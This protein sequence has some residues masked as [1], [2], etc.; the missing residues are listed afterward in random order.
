MPVTKEI[1]R[2][3]QSNVK[4]NMTIPKEDVLSQYQ[5]LLKDYSKN[6]QLP[7]FRKGKVP[8]N[9][10]ERKFGEALREEALGKIIEKTIT[11]IFDDENMPKDEKPLPYS[12]PELQEEPKL[13]FEQ[14][15]SFSI[16]YDVMPK[17]S[18][19]QWKG[20]EVEVPDVS[21]SEEDLNRELE[22]LRER[23]AF[24]LD[25]D[26]GAEAQ[27][28][29]LVT[30]DHCELDDTGEVLPDSERKDF[31]FTLGSSQNAYMFDDDIIGM[32]K[33]DAKEFTKTYPQTPGD[34]VF[35]GKTL[36]L[37]VTLT[38]LKEKKLPD[39]DDDLAQDIDEKFNTLDDLKN[40]I[41]ERLGKALEQRLK[42]LKINGLLE[43]IMENSPVSL[44]ESMVRVELD[45]RIRNL[46]R[47]FGT[48]TDRIMQMLAEDGQGLEDIQGK[49][50]PSAEKALHSRIILETI[51]EEQHIE[52][53]DNEIG[54]EMENMAG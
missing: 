12:R 30:I 2:L 46:A 4:L 43:K 15:L 53:N 8:H 52:V 14:D 5:D 45:G 3:E 35:A 11:E 32:K 24:V 20:L 51:M 28:G 39:L 19:G 25:R 44:P 27:N 6:V 10:L 26:E 1:T 37:K 21:V 42:E 22:D 17:I 33:G 31:A 40:S 23:N 16:V 13:D 9:V 36:K 38:A 49:W 29:D 50:R 34:T 54:K 48:D 41:R 18:I 47:R 7:G